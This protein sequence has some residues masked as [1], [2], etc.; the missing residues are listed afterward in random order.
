M[1]SASVGSSVGSCTTTSA[2]ASITNTTCIR[3]DCCTIS[4]SLPETTQKDKAVK[5][6][7]QL[8]RLPTE[9]G[10][11]R[12]SGQERPPLVCKSLGELPQ[13]HIALNA[14]RLP[15]RVGAH[16]RK[17]LGGDAEIR[18]VCDALKLGLAL[19]CLPKHSQITIASFCKPMHQS[20]PSLPEQP[21]AS[22][23]C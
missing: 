20:K 14:A 10:C 22:C 2:N 17:V 5:L 3:S 21:L 4:V 19:A 7:S 8:H 16:E 13:H 1:P 9:R 12:S 11:K 15:L 6:C 18:P 23:A